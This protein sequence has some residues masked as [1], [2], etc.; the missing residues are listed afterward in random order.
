[1]NRIAL[2]LL[3]I[4]FL[5]VQQAC[6]TKKQTATQMA[7]SST[8]ANTSPAVDHASEPITGRLAALG[9]TRDSHWRGVNLG[10]DFAI[11]K[12]K[13]KGEAFERDAKHVGYTV[14]FANLETADVLYYQTGGKVSAIEVDLFLNSQQSVNAYRKELEPYFT[15]RY[16]TPKS[17]TGGSV[18]TGSISE[19]IS[20]K[21]VSKGKDFGLKIIE[22]KVPVGDKGLQITKH[23]WGKEVGTI[24]IHNL[25]IKNLSNGKSFKD[26]EVRFRY[27]GSSGTEINSHVET[28]Y[29]VIK[30]GKSIEVKGLN[31]GFVN[32]QAASCRVEIVKAKPY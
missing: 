13:E 2:L 21:D 5:F 14:E 4:G 7:D 25:T 28:I 3:A 8:A 15:T 19:Q 23:D 31:S 32:Q 9:L 27:F 24:A 17:G 22:G 20:L 18:W 11:I 12:A 29:Q 6:N 16:G 30:P 26:V 10:D 1:M